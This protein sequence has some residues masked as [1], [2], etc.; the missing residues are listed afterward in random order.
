MPVVATTK[1][2][3]QFA[4]WGRVRVAVENV[5]DLIRIFLAH[6][7]EREAGESLCSMRIK[8]RR[9]L[10]FAREGGQRE[11]EKH[12]DSFLHFHPP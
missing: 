12:R 5:A 2:R 9:R 10:V 6:A 4:R 8:R 7:S 1:R 3:R 11:R